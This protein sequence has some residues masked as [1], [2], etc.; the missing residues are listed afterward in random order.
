MI[1]SEIDR[2][3][4]HSFSLAQNLAEC[5][6]R[7]DVWKAKCELIA[8]GAEGLQIAQEVCELVNTKS[9]LETDVDRYALACLR[10]SQH[11]RPSE[12][13]SR[14]SC[15]QNFCQNFSSLMAGGAVDTLQ[16]SAA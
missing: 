14:S 15:C 7:Q 16:P 8:G 9:R 3:Q 4:M 6:V 5:M 2:E 10:I 11:I 12:L 1:I 13:H